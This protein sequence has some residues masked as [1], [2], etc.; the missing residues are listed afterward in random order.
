M[1]SGRGTSRQIDAARSPRGVE[2]GK[3]VERRLPCNAGDQGLSAGGTTVQWRWG[4]VFV[5]GGLKMVSDGAQ[6]SDE[7][8]QRDRT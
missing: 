7:G 4:F 2:Q 1:G 3:D 5:Q 6:F 8:V